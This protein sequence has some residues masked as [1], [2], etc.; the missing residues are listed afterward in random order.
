MSNVSRLTRSKSRDITVWLV[1]DSNPRRLSRLIYSQIPLAAWVTSQCSRPPVISRTG[2]SKEYLINHDCLSG[3][4]IGS[5]MR[6]IYC[7]SVR[8]IRHLPSS[9]VNFGST[10]RRISP[11]AIPK[12]APKLLANQ[13]MGSPWPIRAYC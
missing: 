9:F 1:R 3:L 12:T 5:V 4:A 2:A 11:A 10:K 13:S 6:M 8:G 7:D